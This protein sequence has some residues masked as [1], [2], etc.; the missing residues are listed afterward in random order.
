MK[1]IRFESMA[2]LVLLIFLGCSEPSETPTK[3]NLFAGVDESVYPLMEKE[4]DAFQSKY[5]DSK[6]KFEKITLHDGIMNFINGRYKMFISSRKLNKDESD[7]INSQKLN[8]RTFKF[9]FE[10]I[11]VIGSKKCQLNKIKLEDLR[12]IL[13]SKLNSYTAVLPGTNSGVYIYIKD[14]LMT[15][16]KQLIADTVGS[17]ENVIREIIRSKN[18]IGFVGLNTIQDSSDLKILK[19]G[20]TN[21]PEIDYYQ[22]HPGYFLN[23]IYPLSRTIYIFLNEMG[24]G[25]ASGFT[26]YLTSYEGQKIVLSQN[27][28]PAAVPV[29]LNQNKAE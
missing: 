29:K 10:G 5:P 27:L 9:C 24:I 12:E 28:A 21:Y 3:G 16:A 1:M 14:S 19:I 15:R 2:M 20:I 23:D 13:S 18:K 17:E 26:T 25:L 6:I 7:F 11:A 8:I 22:P 4:K